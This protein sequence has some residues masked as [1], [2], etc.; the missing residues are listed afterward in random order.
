MLKIEILIFVDRSFNVMNSKL[1]FCGV[2]KPRIDFFLEFSNVNSSWPSFKLTVFKFKLIF[3]EIQILIIVDW[4]S[5]SL[6]F[7][8]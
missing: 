3:L 4:S 1:R 2:L 6:E 5:K 8:I 7:K